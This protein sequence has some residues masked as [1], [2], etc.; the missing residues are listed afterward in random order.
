[1]TARNVQLRQRERDDEERPDAQRVAARLTALR[2][3]LLLRSR[4]AS[5]DVRDAIRTIA[6]EIER[7]AE[8]IRKAGPALATLRDEV[9][10]QSHL[11]VLEAK[12]KVALI[13]DVA[14][15]ALRGA[16]PS[17]TLIG[18]TARLK[19][20]LARMDAVD[21]FEEKRRRLQDEQ[22]RL[23]Q[24]TDAALRDLEGRVSALLAT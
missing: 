10:V 5:P 2:D 15:R 20:A 13:D 1:M 16:P 8:S 7:A 3:E 18:E 9:A 17:P 4:A 12:D 22:R 21:L 23:E 11:A 19:L 6:D 24:T 14:R